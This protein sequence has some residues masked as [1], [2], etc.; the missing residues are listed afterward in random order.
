MEEKIKKI[1][2]KERKSR[3]DEHTTHG[4]RP[5]LLVWL[6]MFGDLLCEW[7]IFQKLCPLDVCVRN[8]PSTYLQ[9]KKELS[10]NKH[11]KTLIQILKS[12]RA[13]PHVLQR[14]HT[15]TQVTNT[16]V[17][18]GINF[19]IHQLWNIGG[20][21]QRFIISYC[22]HRPDYGG[23]KFLWNVCKYLPDYTGQRPRRQPC[24]YSSPLKLKSSHSTGPYQ[25]KDLIPP[26]NKE[27][28]SP[29]KQRT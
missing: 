18:T 7:N 25:T 9:Q 21:E 27:L 13:H 16:S 24:S 12:V 20:K 11:F 1:R 22:L 8:I 6:S 28:N 2:K 4:R 19:Y 15:H 3:K 26:P 23:S 29:T 10:G 14:T 5:H 17:L